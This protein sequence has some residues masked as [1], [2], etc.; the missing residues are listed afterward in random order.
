MD[1]LID[2][3]FPF[4]D[5]MHQQLNQQLPFGTNDGGTPNRVEHGHE[6]DERCGPIHPLSST[7]SD[8][9]N[10][11]DSGTLPSSHSSSNLADGSDERATMSVSADTHSDGTESEGRKSHQ[12]GHASSKDSPDHNSGCSARGNVSPVGSSNSALSAADILQ[13]GDEL[14]DSV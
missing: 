1:D 4:T 14:L 6:H 2:S 11:A 3:L 13:L 12:Q 5:D 7:M 10:L 8:P 9:A